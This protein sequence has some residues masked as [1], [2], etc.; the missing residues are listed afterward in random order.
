M[1][2]RSFRPGLPYVLA[3]TVALSGAGAAAFAKKPRHIPC[4]DRFVIEPGQSPL[5]ANAT[6]PAV[7][8]LD[9]TKKHV[10]LAGTCSARGSLHETRSGWRLQV[11]CA[12]RSKVRL[13]ATVG[14]DCQVLT[15][16][17]RAK[18][19]PLKTFTAHPTH[20][21]DGVVDP[22]INEQCDPPGPTC[23]TDCRELSSTTPTT[24]PAGNCTDTGRPAYASTWQ[25]IQ[26]T[27][28]V[29]HDCGND[30]CHGS[31]K[32][33]GLDLRPD[34]A[35][36]S[37]VG[38]SSTEV[39]LKRVEPGD[40]RRSYF[41]LKL[42]AKTDPANLPPGVQI[43]LNPMPNNTA[44]VPSNTLGK[45]ELEALRLWISGGAPETGTV[46]GT[47][48]LLGV[49][50]PSTGTTIPPATS[51]TTTLPPVTTTTLEATSTTTLP[52]VTTT[53]LETGSTTTTT[54][55][56]SEDCNGTGGTTYAST[57]E[58]IQK[59][60]FT[61]Y[62]CANDLCH[63][64]AKQGALDLRPEVAYANLIETPSSEVPSLP[65]VEPGDERRSYLWLKLLAKTDPG[66]L[67]SYLPPGVQ[68]LYSPMPNNTA[69]LTPDELEA[70]RLWIYA[71][72]PEQGTVEGTQ[73]LLNACL[74]PPTPITAIPLD[75]PPPDQGLQ[76][77]MPPWR[78]EAHSQHELCFATYYDFTDKVP[79][80]FKDGF[81]NFLWNAQTLRQD[82]QSHHLIL[83]LFIGSVSQIH[84]PSFGTWTC[85]GGE[86]DGQVCEPTDLTSCGSGI[87]RSQIKET[88]ACIGYGPQVP[89]QF[90]NYYAIGGA[91]KAQADLD[92]APGV[93]APTPMKGILFWNSHAFNVTNEDTM[94]HGWLNY[95][96]AQDRRY[97]AN[98]IFDV[99]GIFDATG[100]PPY[101]TGTICR[102]YFFGRLSSSQ[103][104]Y[105]FSLSSHTHR[106][107]Q[108]FWIT[109]P[110]HG[111]Q[112]LYENFVY[113]DP[114]NKTFDPPLVFNGGDR[115]HYCGLYNNGVAP[116]GSPD[117]SFVTRASHVPP[118]APGF[119]H[120]TPVACVAG[121]MNPP[122][123]CRTDRD[124]D[125]APGAN[126]GICDACPITGGEST[127]NEMFILIGQY[128][129][130]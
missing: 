50:L 15:G 90:I 124:C 130:K 12:G 60:I 79:A 54:L 52:L 74:P 86:K 118:N 30:A 129:V 101:K 77:V 64:S 61:R 53:T 71:T 27:I 67:P 95:S 87:C 102:D 36:G 33:G 127:E 8:S 112:L 37:L 70:L 103:H 100:I 99:S 105:L 106:H 5:I 111:D 34:A 128:Y 43:V 56:P 110:Q 2:V 49:C 109:D 96:Y 83:N 31:L 44:A 65:R 89:N 93:W 78:L 114:P 21:G 121:K 107:G 59:T 55:P 3:A 22:A 9:V 91:Q 126:D 94:M 45:D 115:L 24:L 19:K 35:Y 18:N 98:G 84:D 108:H 63:G 119:S 73:S 116:D 29:R 39:P 41:W 82:P 80:Q 7:D 46:P 123:A 69:A 25:A 40:E 85:A 6:A 20:C 117:P 14:F 97:I 4:S 28:F 122:A 104:V 51:T 13:T 113:N 58:A 32:Q 48:E 1:R 66:S 120:C 75:P 57:W 11:R 81:G 26:K 62:D 17:L 125:S 38:V 92:F 47:Q 88:F 68:V 76:F 23:G 16:K 42:L 72:A 10:T